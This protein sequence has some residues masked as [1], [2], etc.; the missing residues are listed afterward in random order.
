MNGLLSTVRGRLRTMNSLHT[1]ANALIASTVATSAAGL[2]FWALAARWLPA[3]AVG[4]GTALVSALT[5]LANLATLGLRN[6]VVRFLPSAGA[7]TR[8]LIAGC[9]LAC[10]SAAVLLSV[11]FL[12]GQPFWAGHLGF[13]RD[14]ALTVCVFTASTVVWVLFVLQDDVLVG[15]RKSIWV[16]GENVA[17]AIAKIAILPVLTVGATWAVLAATVLPAVV[18]TLAVTVLLLRLTRPSAVGSSVGTRVSVGQL[19][20]FAAADQ[21]AWLISA[22][23]TPVLTLIVLEVQGPEASAYFYMANM[24]GYSLYLITS[25]IGSALVAESVHDP[26][27]A[28]SLTRA[29]LV[30][31]LRLVVPLAVGGV[32]VGPFVLRVFGEEYA[33]HAGL[34]LQLI[35][36]SALPQ[37]IIGISFSTARVRR[38]LSTVVVTNLFLAATIW[39]GS[40]FTLQWWGVTG[41]GATIFVAQSLAAVGLIV[42]GRT[43][44]TPGSLTPASLTAG[45]VWA[46]VAWLSLTLR[47]RSAHREERRRL[48]PVLAAFGMTGPHSSRTLKSDSDTLVTAVDGPAGE[49]V[50]KI[51]TSAAADRNLIRHVDT[52]TRL[53]EQCEPGF[54]TLL[55]RILDRTTIAGRTAVRET[56]LP[57]RSSVTDPGPAAAAAIA[58]LHTATARPLLV[59]PSLLAQWVEHPAAT[60]VGPEAAERRSASVGR[61][62]GYLVDGLS[63]KTV[64]ATCTHGDYWPGN[65]LV[66][67]EL[68]EPTV[69]GIVDWENALDPGLPDVDLVHWFLS[70]RQRDLGAAVC[71]ALDDPGELEQYFESVGVRLPNPHIDLRLILVFTWLWHV[72]DTRTRATRHGPGRIW[73]ARNVQPVLRRFEA[74][75]PTAAGGLSVHHL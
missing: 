15:L 49:S 9:Y 29:A 11:V 1:N 51:S 60:I 3:D 44:L 64:T 57:G 41:V 6:G 39:G 61:I 45:S 68:P 8:R 66:S 65:V 40:W 63:G 35:I 71:A 19:I 47:H 59:T 73:L 36:L 52:V 25:N 69:T 14:N 67:D 74:G 37:T 12:I 2:V 46:V 4:I 13:L 30:H 43:G 50:L 5:L 56:L 70:T 24:I 16:P 32:L 62:V 38:E 54:S 31:S 55:P 42:F 48:H 20:R 27:H 72:A 28:A 17:Y 75:S 23:T 18:A 34:A 7:S 21:T 22:C 10:G 26:V 53:R 58:C 33:D